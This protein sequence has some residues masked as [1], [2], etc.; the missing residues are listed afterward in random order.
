MITVV[1]GKGKLITYVKETIPTSIYTREVQ[2]DFQT[3]HQKSTNVQI[4][5]QGL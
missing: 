4:L 3:W 5:G 1:E 2:I